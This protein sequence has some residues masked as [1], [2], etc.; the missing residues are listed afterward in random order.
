MALAIG[1]WR[2]GR[3]GLFGYLPGDGKTALTVSVD[4]QQQP[5]IV[6]EPRLY[7]RRHWQANA[8]S[9][10]SKAPISP[11]QAAA[12]PGCVRASASIRVTGGSADREQL[13]A[14]DQRR[15][16]H[17]Q[18]PYR[19]RH[20]KSAADNTPS[21]GAHPDCI[22][23]VERAGQPMQSDISLLNN[24][25]LAI[26]QGFTSF[27]PSAASGI[28]ISIIGNRVETSMPQGIACYGCFDSI[29]TDNVLITLPGS[30]WRTFLRVPGGANNIVENNSIGPL[31]PAMIRRPIP[32][33]FL[34]AIRPSPS[35][36]PSPLL[37]NFGWRGARTGAVDRIAG[38]LRY[39]RGLAP[40]APLPHFR[41]DDHLAPL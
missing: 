40:P 4:F 13:P 17:R 33:S 34:P 23:I 24:E 41:R 22:Q 7:R 26:T 29:I 20:Q 15:H 28:R 8:A 25:A 30:K 38:R 14:I 9:I 11:F 6:S 1:R 21:P 32:G 12:S 35:A 2:H 36:A 27:D 39:G 31:P 16:Q 18:Q 5:R 19:H 10:L 3:G 37:H